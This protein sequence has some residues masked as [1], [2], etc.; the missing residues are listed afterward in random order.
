MRGELITHDVVE[1]R[2]LPARFAQQAVNAR[3]G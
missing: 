1:V 3:H 2:A